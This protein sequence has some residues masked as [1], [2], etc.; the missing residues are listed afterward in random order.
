MLT[1]ERGATGRIPG[2]KRGPSSC[3]APAHPRKGQGGQ[4]TA[5]GRERERAGISLPPAARRPGTAGR[6]GHTPS[7]R[8]EMAARGRQKGALPSL[9]SGPYETL[10]ERRTDARGL[11]Q[12]PAPAAPYLLRHESAQLHATLLVPA[13]HQLQRLGQAEPQVGRHPAAAA[14]AA[15]AARPAPLPP[16]S[17]AAGRAARAARGGR[18]TTNFRSAAVTGSAAAVPPRPPPCRTTAPGLH[19]AA[20]LSRRGRRPGAE[21]GSPAGSGRWNPARVRLRLPGPWPPLFSVPRR[22]ICLCCR[23]TRLPASPLNLGQEGGR[24]RAVTDAAAG[25]PGSGCRSVTPPAAAARGSRARLSG[26]ND[27]PAGVWQ[28][29]R[30]QQQ[31]PGLNLGLPGSTAAAAG[32]G[33]R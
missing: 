7:C 33:T 26:G 31:P 5:S 19:R 8:E 28:R 15:A 25:G 20:P 1:A 9:H 11:P 17:P 16:L 4:E 2:Y 29:D 12:S 13:R 18:G 10:L 21:R 32:N 14:A 30:R 24:G 27:V 23:R 3:D 6:V 22:A